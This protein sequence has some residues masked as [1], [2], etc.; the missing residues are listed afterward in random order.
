G[1][2]PAPGVTRKWTCQ[3]ESSS[4]PG[5]PKCRSYST[6]GSRRLVR[7]SSNSSSP[8]AAALYGVAAGSARIPRARYGLPFGATVWAAGYIVLPEAAALVAMR[9]PGH[10]PHDDEDDH[11]DQPDDDKRL[12]RG[13]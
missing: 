7:A 13:Y 4:R 12:E 10:E 11:R 1:S 6:S 9:A 5:A 2:K 3:V 8:S